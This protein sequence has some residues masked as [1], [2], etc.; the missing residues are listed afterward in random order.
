MG[1]SIDFPSRETREKTV[2]PCITFFS[3][4]TTSTGTIVYFLIFLLFAFRR[5]K[6]AR[7]YNDV[8]LQSLALDRRT[9]EREIRSCRVVFRFLLFNF[10][11]RSAAAATRVP[12]IKRRMA[13]FL[14]GR[15][16]FVSQHSFC[17]HY[18]FMQIYLYLIVCGAISDTLSC[19]ASI[20]N[21]VLFYTC[22]YFCAYA[23]DALTRK[24][25]LLTD[26]LTG[27]RI[28][29]FFLFFSFSFSFFLH[30]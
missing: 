5:F 19:D 26:Y 4:S 28:D 1:R 14:R 21:S 23:S 2:F 15:F 9:I 17:Y 16:F 11:L 12:S 24:G 7:D 8:V 25:V 27:F 22:L 30:S 10:F 29:V 20:N 13:F 18:Y 6:S 3:T